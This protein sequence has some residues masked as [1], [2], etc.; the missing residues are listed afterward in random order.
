MI[1]RFPKTSKVLQITPSDENRK[2]EKKKTVKGYKKEDKRAKEKRLTLHGIF[3]GKSFHQCERPLTLFS[4]NPKHI[5]PLKS[6]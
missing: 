2:K 3:L 5:F 1:A 6:D 4:I